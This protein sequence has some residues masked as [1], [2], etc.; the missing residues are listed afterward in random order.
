MWTRSELKERAKAAFKANYWRCVLVAVILAM[1]VGG[2]ASSSVHRNNSNQDL[3]AE[4]RQ[5][6]EDLYELGDSG[7]V[8][9]VLEVVEKSSIVQKRYISISLGGLGLVGLVLS[10]LVFNP[11]IV[12]CRRFFLQNSREKAELNELGAGFKDNWGNVVLTMFLRN[13]FL[14]LWSLLL[15]FPGIIKAYSYRLVPYI[16]KERPELSGTKAI[17]LSR[18]MMN[19]HKWRAFVL[20]LSFL[21]WVLL[22]VLT[23]GILHIFYVGPY[24]QATDAELYKAI[25]GANAAQTPGQ[26]A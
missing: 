15:L 19:G 14:A 7:L 18:Q 24:I 5:M 6:V 20:D 8:K 4:Q 21:G 23:A 10:L 11:L 16:L 2:G 26:A 9:G 22:S 12:G 13:L 1:L 25:A 17:T 3:T